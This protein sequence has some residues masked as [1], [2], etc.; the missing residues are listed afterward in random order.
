[1]KPLKSIM[2]SQDKRNVKIKPCEECGKN[3]E[4][5]DLYID[6][7]FKTRIGS[8]ICFSCQMKKEDEQIRREARESRIN[9]RIAKAKNYSVIPFELE[10]VSF[11][12]YKPENQ[13]QKDA[14]DLSVKFAKGEMDRTTL[15]FQG[16]T[17]LGKSHLSYCIHQHYINDRKASIFIDLP[18]LLSEIRST[19]GN[20]ND[21]RARTQDDIMNALKEADLLVLDDIGAEYVKPDANGY[22]S[23]AADILFQIANSRQGKKNIYTTNFTSRDL[24]KKYGMMSKRII[25][26]LM[27]NSKV[28]KVEGKDH[29]LKGLE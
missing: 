6:G 20:K 25:S 2:K 15:F 26:R 17:G 3:N 21:W 1:M 27:N 16:D 9:A 8:D 12:D 22:E 13:T 29:R 10:G 4:H 18:S 7:E 11:Q 14:Y 23:W 24:T 5:Y 28:I 19:Y